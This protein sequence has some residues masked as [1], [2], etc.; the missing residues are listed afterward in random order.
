[1]VEKEV[2]ELAARPQWQAALHC[3]AEKTSA[4][5]ADS[6][7]S[8][9]C[10]RGIS[11]TPLGDFFPIYEGKEF[12]IRFSTERIQNPWIRGTGVF[13]LRSEFKTLWQGEWGTFLL[14]KF[15]KTF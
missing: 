14:Q 3:S 6:T 9:G 7:G 13:L 2:G 11:A 10:L 5:H 12:W 1:M 15:A 4:T 8:M